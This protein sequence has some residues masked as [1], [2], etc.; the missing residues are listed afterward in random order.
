MEFFSSKVPHTPK[1]KGKVR[2]ITAEIEINAPADRVWNILTDFSQFQQWNPFIRQAA[3]EVRE[4]AR[5]RVCIK[6][7]G[8]GDMT[9]K[10]TVTRV[11]PQREFRW[12]GHLLI[13]GLFDGEHIFEIEPV[14]GSSVRLVQRERFS[15]ILVPLLWG[16]LEKNTRQGFN[17][18][19]AAIKKKAEG[20]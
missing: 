7:P 18:M 12:L 16:S 17:E 11:I 2:E 6:P 13:P 15:G 20:K 8:S 4:G 1:A 9:F 5:L 14:K 19:N 10:P 3:G